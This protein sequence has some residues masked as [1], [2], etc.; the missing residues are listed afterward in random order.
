MDS[1]RWTL[2]AFDNYD[3]HRGHNDAVGLVLG[4]KLGKS[5]EERMIESLKAELLRSRVQSQVQST[6]TG[7]VRAQNEPPVIHR[8]NRLEDVKIIKKK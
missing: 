5:Y 4:Y 3:V 8:T 2:K 1:R 7:A 6:F